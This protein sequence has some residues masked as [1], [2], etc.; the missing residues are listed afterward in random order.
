MILDEIA[1]CRTGKYYIGEKEYGEIVNLKHP[2]IYI[3]ENDIEEDWI[4]LY[5]LPEKEQMIPGVVGRWKGVL[6]IRRE[7]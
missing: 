4:P 6:V 2:Q 3:P 7:Y 5:R 1:S